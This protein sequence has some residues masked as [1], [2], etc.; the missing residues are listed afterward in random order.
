MQACM[1]VPHLHHLSGMADVYTVTCISCDVRLP[2]AHRLVAGAA[3]PIHD[4][5]SIPVAVLQC[6]F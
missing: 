2:E 4:G 5:H 6:L 1:L 3:I